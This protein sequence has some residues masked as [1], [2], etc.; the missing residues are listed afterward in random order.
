M[1]KICQL[2]TA[3]RPQGHMGHHLKTAA[4]QNKS[5]NCVTPFGRWW[6]CHSVVAEMELAIFI[7]TVLLQVDCDR[8][9]SGFACAA[10][11]EV[12]LLC[13]YWD[14]I[15]TSNEPKQYVL[16]TPALCST[17]KT[18]DTCFES[19][20]SFPKADPCL[21]IPLKPAATL[22]AGW[23]RML[24]FPQNGR[25]WSNLGEGKTCPL[26]LDQALWVTFNS[27]FSSVP[28]VPTS[29]KR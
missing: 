2:Q 6:H 28:Q 13:V 23:A 20:E 14:C 18:G 27:R 1:W 4:M 3:N 5:S 8:E 17:K 11:V 19:R 21:F 25:I 7:H 9:R 22:G 15:V 12:L 26:F 16:V 24:T 29:R 10:D